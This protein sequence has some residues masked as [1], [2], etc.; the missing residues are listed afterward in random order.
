VELSALPARPLTGAPWV[1]EHAEVFR[2]G[3]GAMAIDARRMTGA[4]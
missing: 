4:I 2:E 1:G 3:L